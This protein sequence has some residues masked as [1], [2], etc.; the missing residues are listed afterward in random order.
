MKKIVTILAAMVMCLNLVACGGPDKQPAL[1]AYNEFA[2]NYNQFVE[3][4]NENLSEL[5]A[6]DVEFWNEVAATVNE[7]GT[8]LED[9]TEFTQEEIDDMVAMF[10]E[11]NDIIVEALEGMGQ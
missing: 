9:G 5:S 10:N 4:G 8:K 2:E 6:E 11:L 3:I 7:Y 1:D